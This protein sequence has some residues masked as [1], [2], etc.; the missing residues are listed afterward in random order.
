MD[1]QTAHLKLHLHAQTHMASSLEQCWME[2]YYFA[3]H[4]DEEPNNPYRQG[5]KE[6]QFYDEG[7]WSGFYGEEVLFPEFAI[8][9]E[10]KPLASLL[11]NDHACAINCDEGDAPDCNISE[12]SARTEP[13]VSLAAKSEIKAEA[14]L[15]LR[16][17]SAWRAPRR[18][19]VLDERAAVIKGITTFAPI[20]DSA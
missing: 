10:D 3:S 9:M 17:F 5:S 13:S 6:A 8:S 2:G 18:T 19:S 15:S 20:R 4:G 11:K 12:A 16:T 1:N 14:R 7:W